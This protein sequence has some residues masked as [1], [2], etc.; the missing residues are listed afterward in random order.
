MAS[1]FNDI[2]DLIRKGMTVEAIEKLLDLRE[3]MANLRDENLA[4]K[5]GIKKLEVSLEE[6][7][8]LV[9]EAPFYW[10]EDAESKDGPYCQT[11]SDADAKRIRLQTT[12][13]DF[14]KCYV[15]SSV[16]KG[17]DFQANRKKK[18]SALDHG[19]LGN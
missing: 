1:E 19:W 6:K 13:N 14:W 11:C 4:L 3:S 9:Y 17:A 5:E 18:V 8:K 16:Y 12:G 7:A 10:M 2:S 15:C